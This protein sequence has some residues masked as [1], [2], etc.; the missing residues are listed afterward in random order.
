MLERIQEW[1]AA[2]AAV[3]MEGHNIHPIPGG[4]EWT[5]IDTLIDICNVGWEVFHN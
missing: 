2:I 3:L 5:T 4:E 1:Q